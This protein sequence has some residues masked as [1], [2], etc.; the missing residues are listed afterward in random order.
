MAKSVLSTE[1]AVFLRTNTLRKFSFFFG[2][3]WSTP[4]PARTNPSLGFIQANT[5]FNGLYEDSFRTLG[6]RGGKP[7]IQH[8]HIW[9]AF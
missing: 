8:K 5:G 6:L 3:R 4:E 1:L 9:K 2:F 7:V